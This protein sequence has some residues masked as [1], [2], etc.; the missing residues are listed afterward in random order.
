MKRS[1]YLLILLIFYH[2]YSYEYDYKNI[3]LR[4]LVDIIPIKNFQK[5]VTIQFGNVFQV[6][7]FYNNEYFYNQGNFF[8]LNLYFKDNNW[9]L[10]KKKLKINTLQIA[11]H[12]LSKNYIEYKKNQ[13]FGDFVV[14]VENNNILIINQIPLEEYVKAVVAK[15]VF[16]GWHKE[17]LKVTAIIARTYA[18]HLWE[19]ANKKN[20]LY[21]ITN[22]IQHQ[23]YEG[24]QTYKSIS[25]AVEDTAGMVIVDTF[26][27]SPILAMYHVCCGGVIPIQCV[28][29]DFKKYP[30]LKRR[31]QCIGCQNYKFFNWTKK[32]EYSCFIDKLKELFPNE[33]I[34]KLNQIIRMSYSKTGTVRRMVIEVEV[35]KNKKGI[36]KKQLILNNKVLRKIFDIKLSQYSSY[37]NITYDKKFNFVV[38]GRGHGHH[39]GLCQRG[40]YEYS[41]QGKEVDEIIA[42]YYPY[43]KIINVTKMESDL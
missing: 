7:D 30:Y 11:S 35:R 29:F 42:F 12:V 17:A 5:F 43:T 31:N 9:F 38:D 14:C 25:N 22:T 19:E 23:K 2:Q 24:I 3:L 6:S 36:G 4:V 37:F 8:H 1:V 18:V 39:I 26:K 10:D 13:Y 20:K 15:E 41:K 33:N 21:H 28:G 16:P 34:I 40:M 32:I 27:E